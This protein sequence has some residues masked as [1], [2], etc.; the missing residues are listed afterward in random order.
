[1]AAAARSSAPVRA[2]LWP[3]WRCTALL[4]VTWLLAGQAPAQ[5]AVR[6][7]GLFISVRNP[8]DSDLINNIKDVSVA[9]PM[10]VVI[11]TQA[12]DPFVP[13]HLV[14]VGIVSGQA[15]KQHQTSGD[16]WAQDFLKD[17]GRD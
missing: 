13:A 10:T 7:D 17:N 16:P 15:I 11:T 4:A 6:Q 12:P 1:M 3:T 9:D 14:K 5:V 2:W 8:I